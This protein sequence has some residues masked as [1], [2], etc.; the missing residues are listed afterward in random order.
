MNLI[1]K[2]YLILKSK[3]NANKKNANKIR[4]NKWGFPI[5]EDS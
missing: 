4:R 1:H 3:L 2:I 5:H